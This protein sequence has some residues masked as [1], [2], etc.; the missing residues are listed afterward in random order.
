[1]TKEEVGQRVK[2]ARELYGVLKSEKITQ[3]KLSE[4]I[5][6]SR[7]YI[8]DI[9]SGRTFPTLTVLFNMAD[10]LGIPIEHFVSKSFSL[11]DYL[12]DRQAESEESRLVKEYK[13]LSE[14]SKKTVWTVINGLKNAEQTQQSLTEQSNDKEGE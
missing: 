11:K 2:V 10:V 9:E 8:G 6:Q 5:G 4:M 1:M 12:F 7:S 14:L 3:A 13:S